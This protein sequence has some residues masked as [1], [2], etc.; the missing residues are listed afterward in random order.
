MERNLKQWQGLHLTDSGFAYAY[1]LYILIIV[2]SC[3]SAYAVVLCSTEKLI[4]AYKCRS[5]ELEAVNNVLVQIESDFQ[6]L[7]NEEF[8]CENSP[9]V[10]YLYRKYDDYD[11][12]IKDCSS[13][14][15]KRFVLPDFFNSQ[16]FQEKIALYGDELLTDYGWINKDFY[17]E[18]FLCNEQ[19]CFRKDCD[20]VNSLSLININFCDEKILDCAADYF[21]LENFETKKK[22]ILI[23]RKEFGI[24]KEEL[25][26]IFGTEKVAA[27]DKS[28]T[29]N[30]ILVEDKSALFCLLGVKTTFWK[31]EFCTEKYLVNAVIAAFPLENEIEIKEY[32]I[33]ERNIVRRTK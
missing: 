33:V 15:N 2:T 16:T 24:N 5:V 8:D 32:R 30:K 7:C 18:E 12:C 28:Y 31:V 10:K 23:K 9:A 27:S 17:N 13:A 6:L 29:R 22:E 25:K 26:K 14:I 11:L 20:V 3:L 4:Q 19:Y 1:T 21:K